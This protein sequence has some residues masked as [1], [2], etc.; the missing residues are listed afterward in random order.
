[1]TTKNFQ[2]DIFNNHEIKLHKETVDLI[3]GNLVQDL[4]SD[5]FGGR[6]VRIL[7]VGCGGGQLLSNFAAT[8]DIHGVDV[9]EKAVQEAILRGYKAQ[10][11]DIESET[12]PFGDN[13]FSLVVMNDVL[14]HITDTD[15]CL[16]EIHRVLDSTGYFILGIPNISHP[17]SWFIQIFLDL[18]PIMSARYRSPHIRDFT[19][20]LTKLALKVNGFKPELIKGTYLYPFDNRFGKI[21]A[22][23]FP[24]LAERVILVSAKAARMEENSEVIFDL[25]DLLKEE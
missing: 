24:R 2:R 4:V 23:A 16:R 1:M 11:C 20:R 19:L 12:L 21:F 7:E 14:E 5:K 10:V 15:Q 17:A 6:E 9:S 13:H 3:I 22:S 8:H 25:R 18:P